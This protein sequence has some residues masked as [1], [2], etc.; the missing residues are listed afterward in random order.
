MTVYFIAEYRGSE[1]PLIECN[2]LI[3]H[4]A[5]T[6]SL[7]IDNIYNSFLFLSFSI[8]SLHFSA[9]ESANFC[10]NSPVV[11][12]KAPDSPKKHGENRAKKRGNRHR[13]RDKGLNRQATRSLTT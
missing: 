13:R 9:S 5:L 6:P 2:V 4:K 11:P 3:I 10:R 12:T 8:T 7:L 1:D